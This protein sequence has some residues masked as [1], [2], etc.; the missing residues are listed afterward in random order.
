MKRICY[1]FLFPLFFIIYSCDRDK[2]MRHILEKRSI[3]YFNKNKIDISQFQCKYYIKS[4]SNIYV[5]YVLEYYKVLN[6]KDTAII[7]FTLDD[8]TEYFIQTNNTYN[9]HIKK[10]EQ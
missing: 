2:S 5:H 6:K 8:E 10:S 3:G 4:K 1:Y 9:I 7:W